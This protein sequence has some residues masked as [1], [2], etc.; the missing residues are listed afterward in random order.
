MLLQNYQYVD[1]YLLSN[2]LNCR[3]LD[4]E[5]SGRQHAIDARTLLFAASEAEARS[6]DARRHSALLAVQE[7]KV[8]EQSLALRIGELES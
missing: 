4:A 1:L 6:V 8:N 5:T 2:K 3:T 7:C